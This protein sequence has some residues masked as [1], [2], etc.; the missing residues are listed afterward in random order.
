[1]RRHLTCATVTVVLAALLVAIAYSLFS[2]SP[3]EKSETTGVFV[4][5][6]DGR[7]ANT[8][9]C[10]LAE[11]KPVF[12]TLVPRLP[13]EKFHGFTVNLP[14]TLPGSLQIASF[15]GRHG[16]DVIRY[17]TVVK[18]HPDWMPEWTVYEAS[19]PAYVSGPGDVVG[20]YVTSQTNGNELYIARLI[21]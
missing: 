8:R 18:E 13:A 21:D 17:D 20:I 2:R 12:L 7:L 9:W 15:R 16:D 1:M 10:D 6:T 14:G 5:R 3:R 19:A 11:R 4:C